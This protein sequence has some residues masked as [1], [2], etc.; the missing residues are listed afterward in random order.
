MKRLKDKKAIGMFILSIIFAAIAAT[1][2]VYGNVL[3]V[4]TLVVS[5]VVLIMAFRRIFLLE[6]YSE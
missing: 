4:V 5:Q 3:W 6:R 2:A 1:F